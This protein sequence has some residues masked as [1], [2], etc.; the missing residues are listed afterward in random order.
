MSNFK[1]YLKNLLIA[2]DQFFNVVFGGSPDETMSSRVM[3]YKDKCI[4]AWLVYKMLNTVQ[5]N[6]CEESLESEDRHK[7]DILNNIN[8]YL[9]N[10]A[11]TPLCLMN[12]SNVNNLCL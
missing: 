4:V 9:N 7:D 2:L 11:E 6:H 3:R 10:L 12:L 8:K 5:K 1:Q